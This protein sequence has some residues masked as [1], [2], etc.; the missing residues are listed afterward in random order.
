M[1]HCCSLRF[2][3]QTAIWSVRAS[4]MILIG[5]GSFEAEISKNLSM[6]L[7]SSVRIGSVKNLVGMSHTPTM[8]MDDS[9]F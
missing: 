4:N 5:L 9:L 7:T 6:L 1:L 3:Q 8:I 2:S